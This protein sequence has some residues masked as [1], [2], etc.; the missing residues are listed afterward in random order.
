MR[1][2]NPSCKGRQIVSAPN[3][4]G[5][6]QRTGIIPLPLAFADRNV[7]T[8]RIASSGMPIA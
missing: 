3:A 2:L 4:S 5:P 6:A 8:I 7:R 1:P